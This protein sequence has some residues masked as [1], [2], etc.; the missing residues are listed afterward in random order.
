[1]ATQQMWGLPISAWG[2]QQQQQQV[3]VANSPAAV[4]QHFA[5][6]MECCMHVVQV[7]CVLAVAVHRALSTEFVESTNLARRPTAV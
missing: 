2:L 6:A 7:I 3:S 4:L 1:M 5:A